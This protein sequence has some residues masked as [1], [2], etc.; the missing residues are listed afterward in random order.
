MRIRKKTGGA[1]SGTAADAAASA[2]HMRIRFASAA[3]LGS[4]RALL[5]GVDGIETTAHASP[6]EPG[7]LGGGYDLLAVVF[8]TGGAATVWV[9]QL[10]RS[11]IESKT[12]AI[13]IEVGGTRISVTGRNAAQ[14]LPQ[15]REMLGAMVAAEAGTALGTGA[16]EGSP[17]GAGPDAD[18]ARDRPRAADPG[19]GEADDGAQ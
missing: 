8:G 18:A 1:T 14:V 2:A 10:I 17:A 13:E 12:T 19:A 3:D 15:V 7:R 6:P 5:R 4:L 9:V 11:W 16:R